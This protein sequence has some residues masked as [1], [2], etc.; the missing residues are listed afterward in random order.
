M[1]FFERINGREL[2]VLQE[3]DI[4][5]MAAENIVMLCPWC[6]VLCTLL[7]FVKDTGRGMC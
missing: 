7:L 5:N 2:L 1:V 6:Y 4:L 3:W